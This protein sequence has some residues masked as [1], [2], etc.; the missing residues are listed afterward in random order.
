MI[1]ESGIG[2]GAD[3]ARL[4]ITCTAGHHMAHGSRSDSP[5]RVCHLCLSTVRTSNCAAAP[6][7]GCFYPFWGPARLPTPSIQLDRHL[8]VT[9]CRSY[10]LRVTSTKVTHMNDSETLYDRH[11]VTKLCH[12]KPGDRVRLVDTSA[13]ELGERAYM[14]VAVNAPGKRPARKGMSQGLY[15]DERDLWLLNEETGELQTPP[16]L[17]SKVVLVRRRQPDGHAHDR[18]DLAS[19]RVL[20]PAGLLQDCLTF[21]SRVAENAPAP[22]D[23]EACER[24]E[25]MHTLR[26]RL[27][28]TVF[29]GSPATRYVVVDCS[30]VK[31]VKGFTDTTIILGKDRNEPFRGLVCFEDFEAATRAARLM[32][33]TNPEITRV[34]V[35]DRFKRP[36]LDK[37]GG[38]VVWELKLEISGGM[39]V[40]TGSKSRSKKE[41][42]DA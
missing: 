9:R 29:F 25:A 26:M 35:I 15:D 23:K 40:D 4:L 8:P 32:I 39:E 6:G 13:A 17:S 1:E 31:A 10:K 34:C 30:K 41:Q 28:A 7:R 12:A 5:G 21:V 18:C 16:H 11:E 36:D 19:D 42:G 20:A 22:R 38:Q 33:V 27:D 14:V 24:A 3:W 2:R 37:N